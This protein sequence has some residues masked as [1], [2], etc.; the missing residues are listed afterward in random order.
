MY[1]KHDNIRNAVQQVTSLHSLLATINE[2]L[3]RARETYSPARYQVIEAEMLQKFRNARSALDESVRNLK[4]DLLAAAEKQDAAILLEHIKNPYIQ[5][6]N[7]GV[8]LTGDELAVLLKQN[9]DNPLLLRSVESYATERKIDT[10]AYKNTL[11]TAKANQAPRISRQQA[12][13]TLANYLTNYAPDE[14][15]FNNPRQQEHSYKM[16]TTLNNEENKLF[17]KL[18]NSI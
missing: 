8:I 9:P 13:E 6:L 2:E 12:V 14:S 4:R 10:P 7:S 1:Y 11:Y 17:E 5:L 15:A 3:T 18:D 16:F